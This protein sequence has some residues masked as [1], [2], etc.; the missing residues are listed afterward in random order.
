ML[1]AAKQS[2]SALAGLSQC[3][4]CGAALYGPEQLRQPCARKR[5]QLQ[6]PGVM[7]GSGSRHQEHARVVRRQRGPV[8]RAASLLRL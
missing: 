2:K 3:G 8:M 6:A 4:C 5:V 1:T 7:P